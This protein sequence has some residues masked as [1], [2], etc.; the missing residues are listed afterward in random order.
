M[1]VRSQVTGDLIGRDAGEVGTV[2]DHCLKAPE[3]ACEGLPLGEERLVAQSEDH[4]HP[5][6]EHILKGTPVVPH[7]IDPHMRDTQ[8]AD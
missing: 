3:A 5:D 4:G 2:V 8:D 7:E 6:G 1:D